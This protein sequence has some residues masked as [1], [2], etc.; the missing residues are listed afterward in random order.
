MTPSTLDASTPLPTLEQLFSH[1]FQVGS[2]GVVAQYISAS[3]HGDDCFSD[4]GYYP[5]NR[6][7]RLCPDF[8]AHYG[9]NVY[10]CKRPAFEFA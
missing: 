9:H 6:Y 5:A 3:A 4:F 7:Y 2:D 10:I 8:T 1:A